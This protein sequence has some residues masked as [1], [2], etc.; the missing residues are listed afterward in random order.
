MRFIQTGLASHNWSQNL[1][2][3]LIH[4]SIPCLKKIRF[5]DTL[6]SECSL[7]ES[8]AV[9]NILHGTLLGLYPN[10]T[11]KPIFSVRVE[12]FGELRRIMTQNI[13]EQRLF[14]QRYAYLIRLAFME[15]ILNTCKQ[16][17]PVE[18]DYFTSIKGMDTYNGICKTI[19][20]IFRQE[21]LQ[22]ED[23]TWESLNKN[24]QTLVERCTRTCKFRIHKACRSTTHQTNLHRIRNCETEQIQTIMQMHFTNLRGSLSTIY[25]AAHSPMAEFFHKNIT[26]HLL[27]RTIVQRQVREIFRNDTCQD[28]ITAAMHIHIC[29]RCIHRSKA[30]PR[31]MKLM[32][33]MDTDTYR[34]SQ[35]KTD[36]PV[37]DINIMGRI[38]RIYNTCYYLCPFC[39]KIH[40]WKGSGTEFTQCQELNSAPPAKKSKR[41]RTHCL[42]CDKSS[43]T[44]N[45]RVVT[46]AP[47]LRRNV[48]VF[49]CRRHMPFEHN[50]KFVYDIHSLMRVIPSNRVI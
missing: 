33:C 24:A 18:F 49:L 21:S 5:S 2:Q 46:L 26:C 43:C 16:Y 7:E 34:C 8:A 20:E 35:C 12:L 22:S 23:W 38:L 42:M 4:N 1:V 30:D 37:L 25:G 45:T 9:L 28:E 19:C 48:T 44:A 11:K 10:S 17:L 29:T 50:M 15:Y 39:K 3:S 47:R 14:I 13:K 36:A 6:L 32:R 40:E 41:I 31:Y 27:P